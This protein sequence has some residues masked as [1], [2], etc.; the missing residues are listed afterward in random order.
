MQCRWRRQA[1][2]QALGITIPPEDTDLR[3]NLANLYVT[4]VARGTNN[5][6]IAAATQYMINL[7]GDNLVPAN[8]ALVITERSYVLPGSTAGANVDFMLYPLV[9]A[10]SQNFVQ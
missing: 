8:A 2:L 7:D 4:A 5:R 6:T 9:V 10:D 1:V 3:A